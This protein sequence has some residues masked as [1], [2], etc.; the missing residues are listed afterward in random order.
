MKALRCIALL[1]TLTIIM[2]MQGCGGGGTS[3]T[4]GSLSLSAATVT[5][6]KD[7]KFSVATS[8]TYV[9]PAGKS[10]QGVVI[11]I[12]VSDYITGIVL[13]SDNL[14][15]TSGSNTVNFSF[16]ANQKA[17]TTQLKI[18][19]S[20]GGMTSSVLAIIPAP[21]PIVPLAVSSSTV[22][23]AAADPSNTVST[24]PITISGGTAPYTVVSTAPADIYPAISGSTLSITLLTAATGTSP[25]TATVKVTDSATTPQTQTITVSYFK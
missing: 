18:T 10:A 20:I 3:D 13:L 15:L 12:V 23:F 14:T 1:V 8:A 5:D 6:N 9:P 11:S 19:A 17:T 7:G 16:L 24:P 4:A 25:T 2:M 21:A 22:N